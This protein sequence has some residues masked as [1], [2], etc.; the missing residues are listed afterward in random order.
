[1]S[2][3]A[4]DAGIAILERILREEVEPKKARIIELETENQSL[5]MRMAAAYQILKS[6]GYSEADNTMLLLAS[7]EE[8]PAATSAEVKP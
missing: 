6:D 4:L 1:M 3:K 8:S 5:R 2:D 7:K